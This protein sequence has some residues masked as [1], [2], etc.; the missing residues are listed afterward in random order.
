MKKTRDNQQNNGGTADPFKDVC[1]T[2][3]NAIRCTAAAVKA[4]RA[5]REATPESANTELALF[6]TRESLVALVSDAA[7]G[8]DDTTHRMMVEC[9]EDDLP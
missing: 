6:S 7:H 1:P 4:I 8:D 5:H 2:A 9:E 3:K